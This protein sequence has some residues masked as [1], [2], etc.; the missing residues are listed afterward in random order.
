[1]QPALVR[2]SLG[3]E[4]SLA[5]IRGGSASVP[6]PEGGCASGL[7]ALRLD[8]STFTLGRPRA[9]TGRFCHQGGLD[10]M[11]FRAEAEGR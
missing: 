9:V 3:V 6:A 8:G 5:A 4:H 10:E 2:G 7:Q 11:M 1:M